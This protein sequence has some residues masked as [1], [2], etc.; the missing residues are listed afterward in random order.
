MTSGKALGLY[1]LISHLLCMWKVF[2][3]CLVVTC[4][5]IHFRAEIMLWRIVSSGVKSMFSKRSWF[6]EIHNC[7]QTHE[8]KFSE[9]PVGGKQV[10]SREATKAPSKLTCA[11]RWAALLTGTNLQTF[12][13][14]A[15]LKKMRIF[16]RKCSWWSLVSV[17]SHQRAEP[18]EWS[19]R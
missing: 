17:D 8:R 12:C 11:A 6:L 2:M 5:E 1:L 13:V 14:Y 10:V 4:A 9:I 7:Q 19:T 16:D 18:V 3:I 15:Q